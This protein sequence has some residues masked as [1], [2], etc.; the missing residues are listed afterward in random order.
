VRA[1]LAALAL[2][3]L[4]PLAVRGQTDEIPGLDRKPY[5]IDGFLELRPAGFWLDPDA[6][7]YALRFPTGDGARAAQLNTRVQG[8]L[9]YRT[10]PF[11]ASTRVVL[12]VQRAFGDWSSD[13][14]VY[15]AYVSLKPSPSFTLDVGKKTLK[16]G[17]GYI[18]N[19][20]AFL[21]RTK[22]P[23]DPALALEGFVVV[24]AD[25]IASFDGPLRTLAVTPVLV[26]VYE[27]I[28]E[29]FGRTG[30][31]NAAGKI[32]VLLYDTDIDVMFAAGSGQPTRVG[33]DFSRNLRPDVELHGEV[34]FVRDARRTTVDGAGLLTETRLNAT[35]MVLGA[36]YLARTNTTFIVDVYHNGAGYIQEE[37]GAFFSLIEAARDAVIAG[38][39]RALAAARQAAETGYGRPNTMRDYVYARVSQPDVFGI[40]YL[41][42]TVSS[43][44]NVRDRS[45]SVVGE[46]T[47]RAGERLEL[48]SQA[49]LV[50][51]RRDSEFG[52][53][54]TD[55]RVEFRARYYF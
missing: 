35:S 30:T 37:T 40:L 22:D 42:T 29:G 23:D 10:G 9:G 14:S 53:K 31:V 49:G 45:G 11:S 5:S 34:A 26:P 33:L 19:P 27:H 51:G 36:R 25:F 46:F 43:I 17:K 6:A 1:A 8:D 44:W 54:Q 2:V 55:A 15:E 13:G 39:G 41:A 48:R 4:S 20:A 38:D 47:Y 32:Y 16:W 52:E 21:D 7:L 28:N 18:W 24:S 3:W 50:L 12:D